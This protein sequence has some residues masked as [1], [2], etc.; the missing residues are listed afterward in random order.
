MAWS[1]FDYTRWWIHDMRSTNKV[2]S[3]FFLALVIDVE[4]VV[5]IMVVA[6][7]ITYIFD[8]SFGF[9]INCFFNQLN[10]AVKLLTID[11]L[12]QGK[13]RSEQ[14]KRSDGK[15]WSENKN[16]SKDRNQSSNTS[17]TR[18]GSRK[19]GPKDKNWKGVV[20]NKS[21]LKARV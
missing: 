9:T 13:N 19:K 15:S 16:L 2:V 5:F 8:W 4:V 3:I 11:M 7:N 21:V 17:K 12:I 20:L 6:S 10:L 18:C 14:R 1:F